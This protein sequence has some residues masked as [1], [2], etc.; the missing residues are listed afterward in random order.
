LLKK[1][2]SHPSPSPDLWEKWCVRHL[3][4]EGIGV[5]TELMRYIIQKN[6][7]PEYI[8]ETITI[9]IFKKGDPTHLENY[10][11]IMLT[12]TLMIL[13][14]SLEAKH[15]QDWANE[16]K[17]LSPFQIA[18]KPGAQSRDATSL[19]AMLQTW[20]VR[21]NTPLYVLKK[22]QQKGFDFLSLQSF[23][24]AVDFYGLP[25]SRVGRGPMRSG[26][27]VGVTAGVFN[28]GISGPASN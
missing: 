21:N 5:T 25:Q 20:S 14:I 4:Q 23:Y 26:F 11:G 13:A 6:Y 16:R 17:F 28:I 12:N 3:P 7:F 2:T 8:K 22:D 24:D 1:G 9:T 27:C 19:L 10:R 18:T 15:L